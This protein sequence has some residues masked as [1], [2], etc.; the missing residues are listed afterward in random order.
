MDSDNW[1]R[2]ANKFWLLSII[3]NLARDIYEILHLL[4]LHN[5]LFLKPSE[6]LS[7]SARNLEFTKTTKHIFMLINCHKDVFIDTLKN[8]CDVFI[9]LTHLGFT[10]LSPSYVG[11]LGAVSSFAALITL[12]KPITKLVPS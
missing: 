12:V 6:L 2:T 8:L 10:K 4:Q 7:V 9:P 3:A 11:V 5:S 1:N